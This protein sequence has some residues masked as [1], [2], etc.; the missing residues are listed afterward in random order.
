LP[1]QTVLGGV[2]LTTTDRAPTTQSSPI[3]T[4]GPT[5]TSAATQAFSPIVIGFV[6]SGMD[7]LP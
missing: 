5:K 2:S 1:A 6:T 3:E 4:P 7:H